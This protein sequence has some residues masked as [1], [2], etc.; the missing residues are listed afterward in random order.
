MLRVPTRRVPHASVFCGSPKCEMNRLIECTTYR[1]REELEDVLKPWP[2]NEAHVP[3]LSD[4]DVVVHG[5]H[6]PQA[7]P[8]KYSEEAEQIKWKH[9]PLKTKYLLE[10]QLIAIEDETER[11]KKAVDEGMQILDNEPLLPSLNLFDEILEQAEEPDDSWAMLNSEDEVRF[12]LEKFLK[13]MRLHYS[14]YVT[15]GDE[16]TYEQPKYELPPMR[17]EKSRQ[18]YHDKRCDDKRKMLPQVYEAPPYP[19]YWLLKKK[20]KPPM[21]KVEPDPVDEPQ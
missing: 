10:N 3:T 8:V 2:M 14:D 5:A 15:T 6:L 7:V 4:L 13:R 11:A 9:S 1:L 19:E 12:R 17:R 21:E 20:P 16:K 18:T